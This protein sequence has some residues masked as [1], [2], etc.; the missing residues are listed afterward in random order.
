MVLLFFQPRSI[1]IFLI[2]LLKVLPLS[3]HNICFLLFFFMEKLEKYYVDTW[4]YITWFLLWISAIV[5]INNHSN[6]KFHYA[7]CTLKNNF[8]WGN[9]IEY[10]LQKFSQRKKKKMSTFLVERKAPSKIFT[11]KEKKKVNIFGWKKSTFIEKVLFFQPKML[12]FFFL[13]LWKFL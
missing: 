9:S 3:T 8:H 1:S 7:V 10:Q 2:S 4:R 11:E 6:A 12:T 13:S 5:K